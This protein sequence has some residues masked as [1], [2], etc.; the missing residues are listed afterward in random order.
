MPD[1]LVNVGAI[2]SQ[3]INGTG[4]YTTPTLDMRWMKEISLLVQATSV[5]G[6]PDIKI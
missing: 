6:T 1:L 4:T 3:T 2:V 5:A